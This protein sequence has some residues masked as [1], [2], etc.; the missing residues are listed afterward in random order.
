[1]TSAER[2]ARNDAAFRQANE[3]IESTALRLDI[4]DVP[5][6]CECADP[7]CSAIVQLTLEEYERVRSESTH[8]LTTP[9]HESS[10]GPHARVVRRH[11]SYLVVEKIGEAGE[12]AA[13]LDER[14]ASGG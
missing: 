12:I 9:G 14:T 10:A 1:M 7:G 8:F 3:A 2:V 6:I 13:A 4:P 5:F 11:P